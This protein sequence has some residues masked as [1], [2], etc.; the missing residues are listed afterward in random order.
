MSKYDADSTQEEAS[1]K[2]V[3]VFAYEEII[4]KPHHF[5]TGTQDT[6]TPSTGDTP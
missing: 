5:K 2:A 6:P 1:D 3:K 4:G